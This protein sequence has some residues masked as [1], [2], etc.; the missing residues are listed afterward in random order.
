M[1]TYH[2]PRVP[3]GSPTTGEKDV[4]FESGDIRFGHWDGSA[5]VV[6]KVI[7]SEVDT[8]APDYGTDELAAEDWHYP[9]P[10]V[11]YIYGWESDDPI[12]K[13]RYR[14]LT[15]G[16]VELRGQSVNTGS[17]YTIMAPTAG[18]RPSAQRV[19]AASSKCIRWDRYANAWLNT[20]VT[21]NTDGT[22]V[23]TNCNIDTDDK[24]IFQGFVYAL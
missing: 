19:V 21:I 13:L 8:P 14:S 5:W 2:E 7:N 16:G 24:V 4:W 12:N 10:Q 3:Q 15:N 17:G 11:E 23:L 9:D 1:G 18:H 22:V 6:D 20:E